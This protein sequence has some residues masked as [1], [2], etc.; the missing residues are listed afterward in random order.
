[1]SSGLKEHGVS[2]PSNRTASQRIARW[3]VPAGFVTAA[4]VLWLAQ[5]TM[6]SLGIGA[7]IAGFGE[8]LR[9]W[10]AGHVEKSREVTRSGPY[11][12]TRHPL[13]VGSS[14]IGIGIAVACASAIVAAI[15]LGYLAVTIA[16]AIRAE[17][18]HLREK[19]GP[20]YD[21]YARGEAEPVDRAFSVARAG[22]NREHQAVLGLI[23]ALAVLALKAALA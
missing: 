17:E 19:F 20:E 2:A 18:A 22:R 5:P 1:V 3:R 13:Y 6:Y 9:I 16:A 7:A 8:L 14:V 21:A 10:A 4:L 15:V 23:A 11:R 12:F